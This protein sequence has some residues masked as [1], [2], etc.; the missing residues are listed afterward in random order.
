MSD[1][2]FNRYFNT[3]QKGISQLQQDQS[4]ETKHEINFAL[5]ELEILY[6]E[7]ETQQQASEVISNDL[8]QRNQ[9][10]TQSCQHYYELFQEASIPYLV[11]DARGLIL[12]ANQAIATL[13]N[14]PQEHL[15][16]K[17]LAVFIDQEDWPVF[18]I[19]M[20]NLTHKRENKTWQLRLKPR[21]K[22]AIET[23]LQVAVIYDEADAVNMLRIGIFDMTGAYRRFSKLNQLQNQAET[24]LP[25]TLPQS[26][27]GLRVLFVDDEADA[28]EFVTA[29]LEA[30]GIQV[31]AVSSAAA[32]LEAIEHN[33]PDVLVS[34]IRM[35]DQD[36]Y[37][38][39]RRVRELEAKQGW[40]IPAAALTAYLD[41]SRE[42]AL[43][44]GFEAHLHKLAR[45]DAL[46]ALVGQL[47]GRK[48]S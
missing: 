29:V 44:A 25:A 10:L 15:I 19:A 22:D 40:H 48:L 38:L 36:G 6:E 7:M 32:A 24:P 1:Q 46:V 42:K 39:I 47:S 20:Y 21:H 9:E 41:E 13:L 8:L 23:E 16:R 12:E 34:D 30:K 2:L 33:H 26:L 17:P 28:R 27:D 18:R 14:L 31:Q 45:P 37:E 3:I 11:T 43:T 35:A 4:S 5:N